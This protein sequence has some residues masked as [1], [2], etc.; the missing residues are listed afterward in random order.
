MVLVHTCLFPAAAN[1][2]SYNMSE[3]VDIGESNDFN[4]LFSVSKNT[5]IVDNRSRQDEVTSES[6]ILSSILL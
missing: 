6:R 3:Q 5:N 2:Y 4:E 1:D